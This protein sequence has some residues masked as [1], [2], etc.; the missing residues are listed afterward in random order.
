MREVFEMHEARLRS[1]AHRLLGNAQDAEEIS[2]TTFLRFWK[3]AERY[4]GDCSLRSYLTRITLN[5][6][7]DYA[8]KRSP[9]AG[10]AEI[11]PP[12]HDEE[13]MDRI[14]EALPTLAADDRE[15]LALYYIE[16]QDYDQIGEVLDIS[17]DVLRTRLVRARKRLRKAVGVADE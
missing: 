16:G 14:R 9:A 15:L 6:A 8:R 1:L 3:S 13:L 10:V 12:S 17:Y 2:A 4:R 5:L 7:R 11:E